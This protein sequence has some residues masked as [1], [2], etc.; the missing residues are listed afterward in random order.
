MPRLIHLP[1]TSCVRIP[2]RLPKD[3]KEN[4]WPQSSP[5]TTVHRRQDRPGPS[6]SSSVRFATPFSPT[7]WT[8]RRPVPT[9]RGRSSSTSTS[10][11]IG[12]IPWR[13]GTTI[14]PSGSSRA[15]AVSRAWSFDQLRR[16]S[17]QVANLLRSAG[18]RRGSRVMVMLG[19]RVE[20]WETMLAGIRLGAVLL[21]TTVQLG[22][23]DLEDRAVRGEADFVVAAAEDAVKFDD[24]DREV[25]RVVIDVPASCTQHA[26]VGE[27]VCVLC[28]LR[29]RI[30]RVRGRRADP[31]GRA[32]PPLLHLRYDVEGEDGRPHPHL[33]PRGPPVVDVLD[34][35]GARRPPPQHRVPRMGE[36]RVVEL[37]HPVD[38]RC[39]RRH[40]ELRAVRRGRAHGRHG[41]CGRHELLRAA[42]GVAH[43]DPGRPQHAEDPAAE[44]AGGR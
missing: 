38:R 43:A 32:P 2:T 19:N 16:R 23:K 40:R 5:L 8:S 41:S 21:P 30:R 26:G 24:V 9:S 15:T 44:G 12:S 3:S 25:V 31:G 33:L 35:S 20:L 22:P 29:R 14:P 1:Q 13:R 7:D 18:V 36:A 17:N 27:G 39:V 4:S 6:R 28:G 37:L 34:G 42:H 10:P 11:R